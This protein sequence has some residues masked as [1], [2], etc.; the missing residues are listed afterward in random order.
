MRLTL[1]TNPGLMKRSK[2]ARRQ[3]L[4]HQIRMQILRTLIVYVRV[5][6]IGLATVSKLKTV[7]EFNLPV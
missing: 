2:T 4:I 7:V 5:A 3:P 6:N 1:G